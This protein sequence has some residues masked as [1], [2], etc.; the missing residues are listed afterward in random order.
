MLGELMGIGSVQISRRDDQ[1]GVDIVTEFPDFSGNDVHQIPLKK[2]SNDRKIYA[3][4]IKKRDGVCLNAE[5]GKRGAGIENL[6]GRT[7]F[8][9]SSQFTIY[10]SRFTVNNLKRHR[11]RLL[12]ICSISSLVVIALELA[13]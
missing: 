13:S 2:W 7:F 12:T 5:I 9:P 11:L 6:P 1:V 8:C 3:D 4:Y 10:G